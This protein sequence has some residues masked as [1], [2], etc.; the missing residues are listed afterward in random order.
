MPQLKVS[1][2]S[3]SVRFCGIFH[4]QGT[5]FLF[6]PAEQIVKGLWAGYW[7]LKLFYTSW[8]GASTY[9]NTQFLLLLLLLLLLVMKKPNGDIAETRRAIGDL[10]VAKWLSHPKNSRCTSITCVGSLMSKNPLSPVYWLFWIIIKHRYFFGWEN[11]RGVKGRFHN[12]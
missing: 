6:L 3:L 4:P 5:Q 11:E 7:S 9:K 1:Q 12:V 8:K 10:L 2:S